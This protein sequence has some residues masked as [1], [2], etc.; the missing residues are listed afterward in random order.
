MSFFKLIFWGGGEK[1]RKKK[2]LHGCKNI[3]T[4]I[5]YY[6]SMYNIFTTN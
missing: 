3:L 2:K 6:I 4:N 1:K 5:H